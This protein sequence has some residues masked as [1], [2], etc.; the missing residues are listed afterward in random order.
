MPGAAT[1]W[2]PPCR[3]SRGCPLV[4]LGRQGGVTMM[5]QRPL[6]LAV[7][8]PAQGQ[9]RQGVETEPADVEGLQRR[10][11]LHGSVTAAEEEQLVHVDRQRRRIA[12]Q[13][14]VPAGDQL[15]RRAVVP[16]LL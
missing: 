12:L 15:H 2:S 10:R 11:R 3:G 13:V 6:E 8:D 14:T 5:G 9:R 7:I 16:G 4:E 1:T